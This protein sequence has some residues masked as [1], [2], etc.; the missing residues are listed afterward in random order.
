MES[1]KYP[2]VV[3]THGGPRS[4]DKFGFSRSSTRYN[5]VLTGKGYVVLQPNYRGST[6]YG[7]NFLRDMVGSYFNQSHLDVMTGVDY[8]IDEGIADPDKLIKMGWSAGGHMTKKIITHTDRFKAA[9]SGAEL[10]QLDWYVRS[11]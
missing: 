2:L 3:Q 8:L 7:D 9:S 4:S 5:A 11:K 6:G 10:D 1:K